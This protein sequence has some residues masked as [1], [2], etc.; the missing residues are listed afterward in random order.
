MRFFPH[1]KRIKTRLLEEFK[2]KKILELCCKRNRL[3]GVDSYIG[4]NVLSQESNAFYHDLTEFPWPISNDSYDLILCQH[5]MEHLPD[6]ART[7][8]EFNRITS[9]GGKIFLETPHYTWFEAYRHYEHRHRFSFG[10]FDYF[11]KGNPYYRTDFQISD[12]YIFFDDLTFFLGIGFLANFFPRLYE[13][14]L[15]FIFP[16]TSFHVT[17]TVDK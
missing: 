6:T 14:R 7:L 11:L 17:F 12:K 5:V 1:A 9:P 16:A 3:K 15:A 13:K 10:S 8:E 4:H 2:G